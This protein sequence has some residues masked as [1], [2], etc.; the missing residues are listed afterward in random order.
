MRF[1]VDNWQLKL[2]AIVAAATAWFFVMSTEKTRVVLSARL[3]Y[4]GL[5]DDRV[6]VRSHAETVDVELRAVRWVAARLSPDTVRVRVDLRH[7]PEG[8]SVV[9]LATTNVE[10]PR[11]AEVL[12]IT[13]ARLYLSL[14]PVTEQTVRVAPHVAGTPAAGYVVGRV[15]AEPPVVRIKGPRSTIE[16]RDEVMTMP[17]DVSGTR[18]TVVRSVGLALPDAAY[19]SAERTISVTVEIQP[20][21]SVGERG[22]GR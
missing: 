16:G 21:R 20:A 18:T 10:A 6:L 7:L 8:D 14:A 12:R 22:V 19:L 9:S 15:T 4:A 17:V 13:P 5:G 2:V 11:G 1:L 3:E